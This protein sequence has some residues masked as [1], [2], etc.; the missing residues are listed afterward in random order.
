MLLDS[1]TVAPP[2]DAAAVRVTVPCMMAPTPRLV[3]FNATPKTDGV[4]MVG[5]VDEP[6]HCV[7][8]TARIAVAT[9]LS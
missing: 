7:M 8:A 5:A 2:V 9:G 6:P 3:A 4:A 1:D